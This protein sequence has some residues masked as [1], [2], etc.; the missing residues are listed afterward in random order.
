[1]KKNLYEYILSSFQPGEPF[2]YKDLSVFSNLDS[3]RHQVLRLIREGKLGKYKNGTFF[4]PKKSLLGLP[5]VVST[6]N[7]VVSKY[8]KHKNNVLGYYSGHTFANQIGLSLQVPMIK[9]IVT[10][11]SKAITRTIV[12]NNRT[13]KIRR[14]K[15]PVNND[16]YK[17][18]QL[19]SLLENYKDLIDKEVESSKE[20]IRTYAKNNNISKEDLYKYADNFKISAMKNI[21]NLGL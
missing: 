3:T 16:N 9:E 7:V 19:L 18:L 10:N 11:E 21:K 20:I 14:A 8:I 5:P 13:F 17:V 15:V 1:M 6:D 4:L 2:F 12:L